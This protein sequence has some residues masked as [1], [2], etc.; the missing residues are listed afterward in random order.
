MKPILRKAVCIILAALLITPAN[1]AG[2]TPVAEKVEDK[3]R[4]LGIGEAARVEVKLNDGT[5]FKGYIREAG[6]DSFVVVDPRSGTAT[7]V[8][9]AEVKQIKG[10][11][12]STAVKIARHAAIAAGIWAAVAGAFT[13]LLYLVIPRT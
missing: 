6:D 7:T 8:D 11:G 3:I 5:T 4:S 10:S 2:Q 9:Y 13:L 12:R 1:A